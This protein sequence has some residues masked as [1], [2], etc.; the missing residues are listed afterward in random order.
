MNGF[1]EELDL[2]QKA[3]LE[4]IRMDLSDVL[5]EEHDDHFL[6]R[7][8]KARSFHEEDTLEMIRAHLRWRK[9][10]SV[11]LFL[12]EYNPSQLLTKYQRLSV[13]GFTNDGSIIRI[14]RLGYSDMKG[15]LLSNSVL[16]IEMFLAYVLTIDGYAMKMRRQ[17]GEHSSEKA[18]FIGDFQ[19]INVYDFPWKYTLSM[20]IRLV[21]MFEAN[22]PEYLK[23]AYLINCPTVMYYVLK[24]LKPFMSE[25]TAS[26]IHIYGKEGYQDVFLKQINPEVLPTFLGGT[27]CD[28]EDDKLCS[29][30]ITKTEIIPE[31]SYFY[32][33]RRFSDT[34]PEVIK[35]T[36]DRRASLRIDVEVPEENYAVFWEID[37][38]EYDL[39]AGLFFSENSDSKNSLECVR[40]IKRLKSQYAPFSAMH[41]CDKPG[42]YVLVMDNS[43]SYFTDKTVLYKL[44]VK[45]PLDGKQ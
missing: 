21:K 35:V 12:R 45:P 1:T 15:V 40:P 2:D 22:F 43:Y 11:E 26:K 19:N 5:T 44:D 23:C 6:L 25:V 37:I 17:Q 10:F 14:L 38:P 34:D 7:F 20:L 8:L 29:L 9:H 16:E 13:L 41:I 32:N 30:L 27:R 4:Q 42:K 31:S 24:A 28:T 18:V 39:G 3:M 33:S 36:V